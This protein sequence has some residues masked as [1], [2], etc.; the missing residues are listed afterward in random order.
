MKIAAGIVRPD[1]GSLRVNGSAV[2]FGRPIS[3]RQRG[4]QVVFQ[5]LTV[6]D[7]VDLAHNLFVTSLPH[8]AG[9]IRSQDL[10]RRARTTFDE[11]GLDLDPRARAGTLSV[12]MK[13]VLEIVRAVAQDPTVLLL[14]EPTSSLGREEEDLV[15]GL[16]RKLR[17]RGVAIVYI[18]HRMAEVFALADRIT[19]L[20]DGRTVMTRPANTVTRQELISAMVGRA[21]GATTTVRNEPGREILSVTGLAGGPVK[22]VSLTLRSGEVL[23]LAGLM[24]SG[25]SEV[26]RMIAGIDSHRAG[27]MLLNGSSYRPK[28]VRE[29]LAAGVCYV[30]EDRKLTGLHLPMSIAE[31]ISL[32]ILRSLQ[33]GGLL[34]LVRLR[35]RAQEWVTRLSIRA[36]GVSASVETLSGGNQQKVALAKWLATDPQVIL[37]DEPTRGVDVGAKAEIHDLIRSIARAGAAVLVISSEL[38]EVIGVSDR[39]A[40]MADGAIAGILGAGDATEESLLELAFSQKTNEDRS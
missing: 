33:S 11:L 37:L 28:S 29:S 2:P 12:G 9:I 19:V 18:T 16:V 25:R 34:R 35:Q 24:G 20:R 23:G 32:P 38:P 31:N 30:S 27:K 21:P 13:Q 3:M 10:Y 22:G 39:V 14:D 17:D 15:F 6:L 1:A 40:V 36:A 26:A 7:N 5:E 4:L 8:R